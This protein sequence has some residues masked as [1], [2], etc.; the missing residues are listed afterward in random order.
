MKTGCQNIFFAADPTIFPTSS[1]HGFADQA[2]LRLPVVEYN[3][4]TTDAEPPSFLEFASESVW[5]RWDASGAGA[6]AD[7]V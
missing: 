5:R 6:G 3:K 2:W 1:P 4:A 7:S